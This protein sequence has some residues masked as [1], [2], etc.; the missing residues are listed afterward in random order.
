MI[1]LFFSL[2]SF[3][4]WLLP[5]L[6]FVGWIL[7]MADPAGRWPI[8]RILDRI[9]SPYLRLVRGL[10]PRIGQLDISPIL[11]W[12]VSFLITVLLPALV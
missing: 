9:S 11:I 6:I 3:L 4:V 10:I 1:A 5:L 12:L 2:L 8:T 7:S